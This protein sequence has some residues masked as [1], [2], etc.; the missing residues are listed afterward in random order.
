MAMLRAVRK[1]GVKHMVC[2][3]Y[4]FFPAVRL[5]K[6]LL[7]EGSIGKILQ[8]R[9]VYLQEWIM[10]PN[11]PLVWRLRKSMAD[12][13]VMGDLGSHVIDF[14]RFLVGEIGSTT[15]LTRTFI[16]ERSVP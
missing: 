15:A 10:D 9:A 14:A 16:K 4:R 12:T 5:A 6:Q 3:N 13:G 1:A 7:D 11:F 8:Y 2:Y